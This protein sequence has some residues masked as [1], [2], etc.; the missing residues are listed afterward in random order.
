MIKINNRINKVKIEAVDGDGIRYIGEKG[1]VIKAK[2]AN[3][4]KNSRLKP[5]PY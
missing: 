3:K 5:G 2:R 4:A 1:K